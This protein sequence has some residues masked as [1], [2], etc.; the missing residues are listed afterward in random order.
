MRKKKEKIEIKKEDCDIFDEIMKMT[1]IESLKFGKIDAE[2]R[3]AALSIQISNFH[4]QFLKTEFEMK[5][6]EEDEKI[7]SFNAL[8]RKL[9]PE[10]DRLIKELAT[11]YNISD[12]SKMSIDPDTK[13]IREI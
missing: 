12:V 13:I 7:A 4:K 8:I 9:K 2:I 11:K 6:K 10:Y 1:E 3:N 5:S